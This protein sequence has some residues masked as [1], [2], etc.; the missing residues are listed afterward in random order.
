[1]HFK[2]SDTA[3]YLKFGLYRLGAMLVNQFNTR[4]DQLVIG[5]LFGPTALGFYTIA[6]NL[7]LQPI[8]RLNPILTKVAFPVFSS[9]Q[10]DAPRLKKGFLEMMRIL[11]SLNAPAMLGL[12][13]V[14]PVAIPLLIGSNWMPSVPILQALAFYSLFRS[15]L[16][17]GG[18]LVIA[19]GKANW[20]FHWNLSLAAIVPLVIYLASFGGQIIHI[21][22]ALAIMQ[23]FLLLV[24]Y[25][26]FIRNLIAPCFV[27]YFKILIKPVLLSLIMGAI[28]LSTSSY[29][30]GKNQIELFLIQVA[31]G[32]AVY[33][34]LSW[35]F[36]RE[37]LF[38]LA[39]FFIGLFPAKKDINTS[40]IVL[41]L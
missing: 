14:A 41:P 34:M 6:A 11:M 26:I 35:F 5:L 13:S 27:E 32:G 7:V 10:D 31:I 38:R 36:Q 30:T 20:T 39:E 1:M 25:F 40:T 18:S 23:A 19:K 8:R 16:N 15:A 9:I 29:I 4:V 12:A 3:G 28:V 17:G 22:I 2:F 21:A 33:S 24:Y 37:F